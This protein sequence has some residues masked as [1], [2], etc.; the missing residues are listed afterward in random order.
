MELVEV[1]NYIP[2]PTHCNK[3]HRWT[4]H[5][6]SCKEEEYTSGKCGVNH[7]EE[8]CQVKE[9]KCP[10]CHGNHHARSRECD[11]YK[12]EVKAIT[13]AVQNNIPRHEARKR[14]GMKANNKTYAAVT[15]PT[16]TTTAT[17]NN[18]E[19][20]LQTIL[21]QQ[22]MLLNILITGKVE[23]LTTT[24]TGQQANKPAQKTPSNKPQDTTRNEKQPPKQP[25]QEHLLNLQEQLRAEDNKKR[26]HSPELLAAAKINKTLDTGAECETRGMAMD[27]WDTSTAKPQTEQFKN[28][29]TK[30]TPNTQERNN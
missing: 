5:V 4:H 12:D 8:E 19:E 20:L 15:S 11:A 28:N 10:N 30:K 14:A 22:K 1:S 2:R 6:T 3:C 17:S 9:M 16:T 21:N 13:I 27:T 7:D 29:T 25:A 24:T 26:N 18:L 23:D